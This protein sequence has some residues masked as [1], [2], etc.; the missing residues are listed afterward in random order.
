MFQLWKIFGAGTWVPEVGLVRKAL[1]VRL[2]GPEHL[3]IVPIC[4]LLGERMGTTG[5]LK[6]QSLSDRGV[7]NGAYHLRERML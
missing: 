7:R 2:A 4:F 6:H 1:V 5:D 3:E